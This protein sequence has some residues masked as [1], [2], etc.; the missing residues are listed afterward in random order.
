MN[1]RERIVEDH[2]SPSIM[3]HNFN[4]HSMSIDLALC[5]I[6]CRGLNGYIQRQVFFGG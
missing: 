3:I 6:C 5:K 4:R 1:C 2:Q